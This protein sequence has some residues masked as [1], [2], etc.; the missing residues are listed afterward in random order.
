MTN[1]KVVYYEKGSN[2]V[3]LKS[4]LST[5][6]PNSKELVIQLRY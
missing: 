1:Y 2:V 4:L 3:L 5:I 6:R